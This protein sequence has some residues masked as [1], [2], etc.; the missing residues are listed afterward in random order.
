MTDRGMY[1]SNEQAI[2]MIEMDNSDDKIQKG[3]NAIL[4]VF[5]K[6]DFMRARML[7]DGQM[8]FIGNQILFDKT[9]DELMNILTTRGYDINANIEDWFLK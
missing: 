8:I 9:N 1:L 2:K 5:L 4:I 6:E 3:T 7:F